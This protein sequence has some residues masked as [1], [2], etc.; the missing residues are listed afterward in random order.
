M[1]RGTQW[2][3]RLGG[4][5]WDFCIYVVSQHYDITCSLEEYPFGLTPIY[6]TFMEFAFHPS[7]ILFPF[8]LVFRILETFVMVLFGIGVSKTMLE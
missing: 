8:F 1:I 2:Q 6:F 7:S 5:V 3:Y 4:L